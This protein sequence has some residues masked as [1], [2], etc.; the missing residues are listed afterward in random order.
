MKINEVITEKERVDEVLPAVIGGLIRAA[1]YLKK[2]WDAAKHS[3]PYLKKLKGIGTKAHM[4]GEIGKKIVKKSPPT[5]GDGSELAKAPVGYGTGQVDPALASAAK[6]RHPIASPKLPVA[7][8]KLTKKFG[9]PVGPMS[10]LPFFK[11]KP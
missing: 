9:S 10:K 1:P 6:K 4:A 3:L 2:G 8:P 11:V 7:S 5:P